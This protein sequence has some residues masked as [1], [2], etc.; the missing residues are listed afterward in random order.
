[1]SICRSGKSHGEGAECKKENKSMCRKC[2][3][4]GTKCTVRWDAAAIGLC[5][6][7]G[8]FLTGFLQIYVGYILDVFETRKEQ[9][10]DCAHSCSPEGNMLLSADGEDSPCFP[11][12]RLRDVPLG[13]A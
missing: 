8:T 6:I 7:V 5:R 1:M 9:A 10:L 12:R 2:E 4:S 11:G 3:K 13:V